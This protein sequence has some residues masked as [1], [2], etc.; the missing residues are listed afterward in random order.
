MYLTQI[1]PLMSCYVIVWSQRDISYHVFSVLLTYLALILKS[2]D[3]IGPPLKVKELNHN[4]F[5]SW[6]HIEHL[7]PSK[8]EIERRFIS[9]IHPV[10]LHLV[11]MAVKALFHSKRLG[12]VA[13][14]SLANSSPMSWMKVSWIMS[15]PQCFL[16]LIHRVEN[17]SGVS[18]FYTH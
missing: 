13:I 14:S 12:W 15:S 8:Q 9:T 11:K 1:A 6:D 10:M 18:N 5:K 3:Q 16:T 17:V 4:F 7:M 2:K